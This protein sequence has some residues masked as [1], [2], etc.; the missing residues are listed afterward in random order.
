MGAS[1]G[2]SVILVLNQ[3]PSVEWTVKGAGHNPNVGFSSAGRVLIA[4][5]KMNSTFLD[6][7][8]CAHFGTGSR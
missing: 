3:S 1:D 6:F 8:N 7:K 2:A 5:E 4:L